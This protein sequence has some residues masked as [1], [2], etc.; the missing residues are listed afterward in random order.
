MCNISANFQRV[1]MLQ[2]GVLSVPSVDLL[3]S[4]FCTLL[5]IP[6][7]PQTVAHRCAGVCSPA[8]RYALS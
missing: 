6:E 8:V 7:L 5:R 4:V 2:L 3:K 1:Q